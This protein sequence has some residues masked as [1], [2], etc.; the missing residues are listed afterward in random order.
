MADSRGDWPWSRTANAK[1]ELIRISL[2]WRNGLHPARTAAACGAQRGRRALA[3][4]AAAGRPPAALAAPG[5]PVPGWAGRHR[6]AVGDDADLRGAGAPDHRAGPGRPGRG[7]GRHLQPD[8][9]Q[10][11]GRQPG[12]DP[13]LPLARPRGADGPGARGRSGADRG[14]PR[15]RGLLQRLLPRQAASAEPRPV[16]LVGE[17]LDR[18]SVKREGKS[19]VIALS[20]RSERCREGGRGREQAGR[21]L[22]GRPA[23]PEDA[24]SRRQSGRFDDQLVALKGRLAAAEAALAGFRAQSEATRARQPGRGPGRDRRPRRPA[25]RGH[26]RAGRPG[27]RCSRAC[28]GWSRAASEAMAMGEVGGS[29]HARQP[30]GAQGR[31]VAARGRVR[32]P[33]RRAP[34]QDP[35]HPGREGEARRRIREERKGVLRQY[36]GRGRPRPGRRA[37]PGRQAR[38]AEGQ[39]A[40]ARGQRRAGP[41]SW[42]ARSS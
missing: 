41:R 16:D 10:R 15:R 39:G 28:A 32:R 34:P 19:H 27:G 31:A 36:R 7:H 2:L 37:D 11:L 3:G 38:G 17:F 23:Q 33:V 5:L 13:G 22:H 29:P 24:A 12:A 9:R 1:V 21:A 26:G 4:R 6:R 25:G 8:A 40:A 42:S 30:A 20:W 35:G 18:L 14:R